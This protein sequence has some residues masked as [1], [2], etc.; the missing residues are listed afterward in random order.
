MSLESIL[1][2]VREERLLQDAKWGGPAHDDQHT[3]NDWAAIIIR[4]LGLGF[5]DGAEDSGERYRKQLIRVA[6][7]C[8]AAVESYDRITNRECSAGLPPER[9]GT[10]V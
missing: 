6:A 1:M 10:G 3:P 7:T 9:R 2:R 5:S 4:H 8:L